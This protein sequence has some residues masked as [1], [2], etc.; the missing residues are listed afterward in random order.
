M[1][2]RIMV[3]GAVLAIGCHPSGGGCTRYWLHR[4]HSSTAPVEPGWPHRLLSGRH[5]AEVRTAEVGAV[6]VR[7]EQVGVTEVRTVKARAAEV[8]VAEVHLVELRT[9][10]PRAVEVRA[11]K[12]RATEVGAPEVCA[13]EEGTRQHR[14]AQVCL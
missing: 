14:F 6:E 1:A 9:A 3:W 2:P 13:A 10:E 4:L 5:A 8:R 12:L 7:A 11:L